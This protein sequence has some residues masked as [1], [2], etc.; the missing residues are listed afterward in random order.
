MQNCL[1]LHKPRGWSGYLRMVC[2][3]DFLPLT[4]VSVGVIDVSST[5]E[6]V[7]VARTSK[8][9]PAPAG[10]NVGIKDIALIATFRD[11]FCAQPE[12]FSQVA[13]GNVQTSRRSRAESCDLAGCGL[14]QVGI[15]ISVVDREDV[16]PIPSPCQQA[17]IFIKGERVNQIFMG[18]PDA[19]RRSIGSNAVDFRASRHA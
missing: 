19:R 4:P 8:L 2:K 5:R 16:T 10:K 9:G 17:S 11:S 18:T 15:T 14:E 1:P 12:H 6:K 7:D 13:G 3:I